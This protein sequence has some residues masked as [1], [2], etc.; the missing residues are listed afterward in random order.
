MISR[1]V[2]E[3]EKNCDLQKTLRHQQG[4]CTWREIWKYCDIKITWFLE[5]ITCW[6]IH[7]FWRGNWETSLTLIKKT[8][9]KVF[10]FGPS[11]ALAGYP[12]Q[13]KLIRPRPKDGVWRLLIYCKF[14]ARLFKYYSGT[15]LGGQGRLNCEKAY[16]FKSVHKPAV[17]VIWTSTSCPW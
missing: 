11:W 17:S 12:V 15:L 10:R 2:K 6:R 1:A 5:D 7:L 13:R 8:K 14:V 3:A 4:C 16:V 9:F